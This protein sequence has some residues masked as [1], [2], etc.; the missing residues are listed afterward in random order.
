MLAIS[1]TP[2]EAA[3]ATVPADLRLLM[4]HYDEQQQFLYLV[5]MNVPSDA[6]PVASK[7]ATPAASAKGAKGAPPADAAPPVPNMV[8]ID[9]VPVRSALNLN[10]N[11]N[12]NPDA[13]RS[14]F[15]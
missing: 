11:P 3:L 9:R 7:E 12:P 1:D 15:L 8:V 6:A 4:L 5:A 13:G 2:L 14:C 10:C